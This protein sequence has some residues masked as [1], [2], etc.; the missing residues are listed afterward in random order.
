[1]A[2]GSWLKKAVGL[3]NDARAQMH[4][5]MDGWVNFLTGLN[6]TR[7]KT[8]QTRPCLDPVLSP[9]ELEGMYHSDDI[10]ARIVSAIPD[11]AF[12]ENFMVISKAA[13]QEVNEFLDRSPNTKFDDLRIVART[14]MKKEH[15]TIQQQANELQKACDDHGMTQKLREAMTWGRLYGLG[16]ILLGANDGKEFWEPLDREAVTKVTFA[17]V[18]DKRDLTPWRWYADPQAPKFSDVAIYLM[19]PVGVYVGAP[20]DIFNTSQVLLVHESRMI[21]F[22]GELTSK[23]LRL[24]NQGADYSVLQKCFRALQLVND[25]WQSAAALLAD[26]SQAVYKIRG[27]MDMIAADKDTLLTRFQFLDVVRSTFRAILLEAGEGDNDGE[28]FSRVETPFQGIPEMLDRSWT[29]AA[30]AAR[31]PKQILLGEPPGGLNAGGTADAN[32]RWWYDTVKATQNQGVKPQIE[33]YLFLEATA[34][35]FDNPGDWSVVFPPLWQLTAKEEAEMHLTQAQADQIEATIG[36]T[37]PEEL[38]LSRHGGG[39]YSLDTKIDVATRKRTM[40]ASLATMEQEAE[41]ELDSAAD[42]APTPG[43]IAAQEQTAN[44]TPEP[45]PPRVTET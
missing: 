18:L 26:A 21:R 35:G 39:K 34:R 20:Y 29:R 31:M 42:P 6:S 45:V 12:R 11:E 13:Q 7:D 38:A 30:A 3:T 41:N 5:R 17:T 9:L 2:K 22:G 32:V 14:A 19:Q 27:L 8:T 24:A 4:M 28:D 25:N 10:A 16:A 33:Y 23:R 36:M 43:V 44:A 15:A 37:T 40:A 1:M